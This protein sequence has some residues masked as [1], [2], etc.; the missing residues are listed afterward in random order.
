[1]VENHAL[2][3][4]GPSDNGNNQESLLA[5]LRNELLSKQ[6]EPFSPGQWGR[7]KDFRTPFQLQKSGHQAMHHGPANSKYIIQL[8]VI[9]YVLPTGV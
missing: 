6:F 2:T 3:N 8:T 4:I 7:L 5:K 1:V 9:H